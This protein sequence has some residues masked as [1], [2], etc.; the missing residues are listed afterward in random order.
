VGGWDKPMDEAIRWEMDCFVDLIR[1]PVAGNMVRTLFLNRQRA[2]KLAP[3]QSAAASARVAVIG[4]RGAQVERLLESGK[5]AL[6]SAD[7]LTGNDIALLM[8]AARIEIGRRVA[9]LESALDSPADVGASTGIWLSE[10]TQH[11]RAAE[12]VLTTEDEPAKDA[13]IMLTRWLGA[14]PLLTSGNTSL[15]ARLR[16]A[17]SAA[18]NADCTESDELLAVALAAAR[19]WCD[20]DVSDTSLADVAAVIA[21][22]H[23]AYGGGP[24]NYLRQGGAESL[25]LRSAAAALR[26]PRLFALAERVGEL[27]SGRGDRVH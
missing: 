8:P 20:G 11:G 10:A 1:D 22:L 26:H 17:R 5:A 19:A 27:L 6:V 9:W 15:L 4:E 23:P 25:R 12:I 18:R 24:F 14:T 3:S 7:R 16:L 13:A 2:A 21:G